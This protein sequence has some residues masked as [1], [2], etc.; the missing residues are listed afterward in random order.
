MSGQPDWNFPLFF[1][2]ADKLRALGYEPNN[3]AENDGPDVATA[4]AHANAV[5]R[6]GR[7]GWAAYMKR[8]VVR[9]VSCDGVVLLPGWENS[10]GARLEARLARDLE[11]PVYEWSD[12]HGLKPCRMLVH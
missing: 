1:A 9:L 6:A 11:M 10:R 5:H 8:D 12:Q 3:P 7:H 4:I 2:V